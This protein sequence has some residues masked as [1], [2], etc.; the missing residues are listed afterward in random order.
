M[1]ELPA[2]L[3]Y[4]YHTDRAL[5]PGSLGPD[6]LS[7]GER[8]RA[9]IALALAQAT[10]VLLLD[11]PTTFLDIGHQLEV[12]ELARRLHRD[13]GMTIVLVLHYLKPADLYA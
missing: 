6:S 7:G 10:P 8:Q 9:W 3:L 13:R 1:P 2:T 4:A 11:E 5:A 12:L